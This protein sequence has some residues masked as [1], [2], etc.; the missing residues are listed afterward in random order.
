MILLRM[1]ELYLI[2]AEA[3]MHAGKS[4]A[5]GDALYYLNMVRKRARMCGDGVIP[6]DLSAID[7][8]AIMDER[9]RELALEGE[10]FFDLVRCK[11]ANRFL[12]HYLETLPPTPVVFEEGK[13]DFFPLPL[14]QVQSSKGALTQ[15]EGW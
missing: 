10:R 4:G 11:M 7:Q 5:Y 12:N 14:T 3:A 6:A 9:L 1:G 8:D 13:N 15:Y 2:A